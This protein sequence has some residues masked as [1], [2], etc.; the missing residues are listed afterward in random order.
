VQNANVR[1]A[2]VFTG[3]LSRVGRHG[4][5]RNGYDGYRRTRRQKY[6][7][8]RSVCTKLYTASE[9]GL[10]TK[11]TMARYLASDTRGH[12]AATI[13]ATGQDSPNVHPFANDSAAR[14]S[15]RVAATLANPEKR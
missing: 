7:T 15:P 6:L 8:S 9:S 10:Q 4:Y 12:Q 5:Q 13:A 3:F 2:Q 14:S 1:T 11:Q